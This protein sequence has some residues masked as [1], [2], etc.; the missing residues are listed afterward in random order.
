MK[1]KII[2]SIDKEKLTFFAEFLK[3][4]KKSIFEDANKELAHIKSL[5][6]QKSCFMEKF[7][8]KVFKQEL[9]DEIKIFIFPKYFYL[10][11]TETSGHII[12]FGQP[13]RTKN[14]S[15]AIIAH[16]IGHIFLS[17]NKLKRPI[18]VDEV[19]CFMLEDYVY[20]I[21][22]KKSLSNIWKENELDL[23]HL[24]AMKIAISEIEKRGP[25]INRNVHE[26]INTLIDQ[27]DRVIIK[28]K[29]EKGLIKNITYSNKRIK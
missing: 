25:I 12:L 27:L 4:D 20:S 18:I 29:P 13:L 8:L 2:F 14:F 23:F 16:E 11:A 21:F 22:D 1:L 9:G 28:L 17:K 10:G 7:F 3:I 19:I 6:S 15:S 5:W 26:I 24:N